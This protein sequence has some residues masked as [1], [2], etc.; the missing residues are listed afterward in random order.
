MQILWEG[1]KEHSRIQAHGADIMPGM[2]QLLQ[3]E[4]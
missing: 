4:V 2:Q 3:P 1:N